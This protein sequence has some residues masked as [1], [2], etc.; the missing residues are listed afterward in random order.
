MT[1]LVNRSFC[2]S[3]QLHQRENFGNRQACICSSLMAFWYSI[4]I[5]L[6]KSNNEI[7]N[8]RSRDNLVKRSSRLIYFRFF[9]YLYMKNIYKY[10]QLHLKPI[11]YYINKFIFTSMILN[12][13]Y[14]PICGHPIYGQRRDW[15]NYL[16]RQNVF[17][18][19][20]CSTIK[21][22]WRD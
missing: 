17:Q 12:S 1:V 13:K 8:N 5:S 15:R 2:S 19:F 21:Y 3:P 16:S 20:F 9:V 14:K 18:I 22:I 6:Q 7:K 4:F 10:I 11:F